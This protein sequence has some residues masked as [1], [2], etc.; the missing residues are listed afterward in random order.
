MNELHHITSSEGLMKSAEW[1][2]GMVGSMSLKVGGILIFLVLLLEIGRGVLFEEG[3]I[4][5][6]KVIRG[7]ILLFLIGH[8]QE[9][10]NHISDL[11]G[12]IIN[13]MPNYYNSLTEEQRLEA[14]PP[15]NESLSLFGVT[16]TEVV[17]ALFQWT[18]IFLIKGCVDVFQDL[19]LVF[20]Y[21]VGPLSLCISLIPGLERTAL[22]WFKIYIS[23]HLWSLSILILD[24]LLYFYATNG[25]IS[26]TDYAGVVYIIVLSIMYCLLPFLTTLFVGSSQAGAFMSKIIGLAAMAVGYSIASKAKSAGASGSQLA[27]AYA[28]SAHSTTSMTQSQ[29]SQSPLS[30]ISTSKNN[31]INKQNE[32]D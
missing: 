22:G 32:E 19:L 26:T 31:H 28:G 13:F 12:Y 9:I 16:F 11:L 4:E 30:Q 2:A 29:S 7:V 25:Y 5:Y 17:G 15:G 23:V 24:Y 8:Y 6:K 27:P 20:L 10:I 3:R 18:F 14:F 1:I 21:A